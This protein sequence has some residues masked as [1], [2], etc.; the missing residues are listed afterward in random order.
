MRLIKSPNRTFTSLVGV[1]QAAFDNLLPAF[2]QVYEEYAMHKPKQPRQRK[3]GGGAKP[4]L[5]ELENKLLMILFYVKNYP[6]QDVIGV[7]Y[8]Q[9]QPWAN[10][11]IHILMPMVKK[12]LGKKYR[13]PARPAKPASTMEELFKRCPELKFI[14]DST[15]RPVQRP[16][17]KAQQKTKYSGKKKRHTIKNTILTN[18]RTKQILYLGPTVEGKKHDKKMA[19]EEQIPFPEKSLVYDDLGYLGY[20]PPGVRIIQ[21]KKKPKGSE[22]SEFDKQINRMISSERIGVEHSIGGAKIFRIVR[23]IYRNKKTQFD[24]LVMEVACGLYNHSVECRMN[25]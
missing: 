23:D 25:G 12:S 1:T 16:K 11:W 7:L 8:G 21:P 13:L 15:E 20:N 10:K 6:T 3:P 22:L 18:H 14:L 2:K 5:K 19:D 17:D 4:V 9:T 24:D